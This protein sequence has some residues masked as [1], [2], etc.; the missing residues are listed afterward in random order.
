MKQLKFI[1]SAVLLLTIFTVAA[2]AQKKTSKK[3]SVRRPATVRTIPPLDV[4]VAREKVANQHANVKMF[5]DRLG[6]VAQEI[7]NIDSSAKTRRLTKAA[8]DQNEANKQKVI[9][10][11]RNLKIGLTDLETEFRTKSSLKKYLSNIQGITELAADS[12]DMAIAG[13]F[14]MS[15]E[16]LRSVTQKLT[17]TL[18]VIPK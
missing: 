18:A 2:E 9:T 1:V 15:K 5:V 7:E 8:L 4:R 11:I 13:K 10:A 3:T 14:V 12:E 16:P 6:P 17:D